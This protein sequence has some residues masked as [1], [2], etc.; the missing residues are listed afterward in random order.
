M[1]QGEKKTQRRKILLGALLT[2]LSVGI[3]LLQ[4]F[5]ELTKEG[6]IYLGAF[7]WMITMMG[8][9]IIPRFI[10]PVITLLFLVIARVTEFQ[11]AFAPF[12]SATMWMVIGVFGVSV[13]IGNSGVLNRLVLYLLRPFPETFKGQILAMYVT[14]LFLAPLVP[15][16]FGKLAILSP[17]AVN[18]AE[19]YGYK[20]SSK[21]AIGIFGG[22]YIS[23]GI[24]GHAFLTGAA[25]VPIMIG[26]MQYGITEFN[27]FTW[28]SGTWVWLAVMFIGSYLFIVTYY[29]PGKN[30]QAQTSNIR[31]EIKK[32]KP[33][34]R[35]EIIVLVTMFAAV[36]LWM[37]ETF[38]GV[39]AAL[40]VLCALVIFIIT[41]VLSP[42]DFK[43]K[44]DWNTAIYVGAILGVMSYMGPLGITKWAATGLSAFVGP[45]LTNPYIFV[46]TL[47][48]LTFIA[49]MLF[50][51]SIA[52]IAVFTAAFGS[53]AAG[54]GISSFII[55][56][57]VYLVAQD[58]NTPFTNVPIITTLATTEHKL[59]E[60]KDTYIM[61]LA[62]FVFNVVGFLISVPFWQMSGFIQ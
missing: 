11:T 41:G 13:A 16:S 2:A 25:A 1:T 8:F 20:K 27:F 56:Y 61:N 39:S 19:R 42:N 50:M 53:L 36:V 12:S 49:R 32:L 33:I 4:P 26:F 29:N 15:S 51:S 54:A 37:T 18:M 17:V 43:T 22:L 31:A 23:A 3:M 47:C 35:D 5:G 55:V 6:M 57:V 58:W 28:L 34:S 48:A 60:Y 46:L 10:T 45:A 38:H 21:G 24:F 44:I 7:T 40:V 59:V 52:L 30:E 9:G 62:Y 14:N